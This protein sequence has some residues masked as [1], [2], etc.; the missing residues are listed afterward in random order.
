V[1]PENLKKVWVPLKKIQNQSNPL[2]LLNLSLLL[3]LPLLRTSV[4]GK[5]MTTKIPA[6]PNS[7]NP[8]TSNLLPKIR[9]SSTPTP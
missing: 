4:R 5:E 8:P 6:H 1:N 9:R 7:L 2:T 3:L